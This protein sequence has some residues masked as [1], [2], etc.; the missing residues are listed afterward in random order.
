VRR[1]RDLDEATTAPTRW[2]P[3]KCCS[4]RFSN[5][6]LVAGAETRR[7]CRS[8]HCQAFFIVLA[9]SLLIPL[10]RTGFKLLGSTCFF[11][12]AENLGALRSA[13]AD[14]GSPASAR[15]APIGTGDDVDPSDVTMDM[16]PKEQQQLIATLSKVNANVKLQLFY[17][18]KR[19]E[20]LTAA[21]GADEGEVRNFRAVERRNVEQ[22]VK[23]ETMQA[24]LKERD[25][26]IAACSKHIDELETK[27]RD[28][29]ARGERDT[30]A[31]A[32]EAVALATSV[33]AETAESVLRELE[34]AQLDNAALMTR[35]AS[36]EAAL[37]ALRDTTAALEAD[38]AAHRS[39]SAA[40]L[41]RSILSR[42]VD[43]SRG[44]GD[45]A[46]AK[47]A[48]RR[49]GRGGRGRG[50]Q[51]GGR[52]QGGGGAGGARRARA[53]RRRVARGESERAHGGGDVAPG[54]TRARARGGARGR[55][56]RARRG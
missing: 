24:E 17:S 36:A 37:A 55:R 50:G 19:V 8:D 27:M 10:S 49:G 38:V 35:A 1:H 21:L 45:R 34:H 42:R 18:E 32:D 6:I 46:P 20:D 22:S 26:I 28:A 14:R 47:Q 53:R 31:R 13:M 9:P 51:R 15:S 33:A 7:S 56:A 16:T 44:A 39:Q 11:W 23:I 52:R 40:N 25:D 12:D 41:R 54:G 30:A 3:K 2:C 48:Q 43:A 29:R 4:G 5:G